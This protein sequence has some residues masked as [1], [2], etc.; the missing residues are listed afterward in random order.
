ME[1]ELCLVGA[2]MMV[3]LIEAVSHGYRLQDVI[4]IWDYNYELLADNL[5]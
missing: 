3:D 1:E 5:F 2:W 4:E